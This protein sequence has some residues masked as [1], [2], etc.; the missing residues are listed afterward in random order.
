VVVRE[1]H[2]SGERERERRGEGNRLQE[3]GDPSRLEG[4]DEG[5]LG[6]VDSESSET[7][8]G[9]TL[10]SDALSRGRKA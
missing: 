8:V 10:T 2:R 4:V 6:T 9:L 7:R 5:T 1:D 3:Q